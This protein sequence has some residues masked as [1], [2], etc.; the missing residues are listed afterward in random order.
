MYRTVL[1][2]GRVLCTTPY[3]YRELPEPHST[4]I[5]VTLD[6]I[7]IPIITLFQGMRRF[8]VVTGPFTGPERS[9]NTQILVV[10]TAESPRK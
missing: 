10:V 8:L 4:G 9:G 2:T 5:D 3:Q 1:N 6:F 7:K